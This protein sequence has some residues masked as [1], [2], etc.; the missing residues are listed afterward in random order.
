MRRGDLDLPPLGG[1][2]KIVEADETCFGKAETPR[3]SPQRK[4]KRLT[5]WQPH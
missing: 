2:G 5:Y 1:P 4:G 3:V